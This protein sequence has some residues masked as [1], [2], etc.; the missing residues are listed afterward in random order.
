MRSATRSIIRTI[1]ARR[2]IE[3]LLVVRD[4]ETYRCRPCVSPVWDT[5]LCQA[6][7]I[8]V[9]RGEA[10]KPPKR[11][12]RWLAPLQVLEVRGDWAAAQVR[13][14]A[15]AFQY[16]NAHYPDLDDTAVVGDDRTTP[17][18]GR[19]SARMMTPGQLY[20]EASPA[21][22]RRMDRGCSRAT[23]VGPPSDAD[24]TPLSQQHPVRR[25]RRVARSADGRCFRH[26][27]SSRWLSSA[28]RPPTRL[29]AGPII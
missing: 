21:P 1:T 16:R 27:A 3:K 20:D 29:C 18:G 8:Q 12:L 19:Q 9:R 14:P 28:R 25:P 2:S 11:G 22:R 24:N 5:T 4:D 10:R 17:I 7:L 15:A 13:R 6:C 23:A 26:A